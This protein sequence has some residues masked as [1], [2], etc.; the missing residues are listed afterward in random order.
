M[1]AAVSNPGPPQSGGSLQIGN[2]TKGEPY[3]L[4][5]IHWFSRLVESR[6]NYRGLCRRVRIA[7]FQT[8]GWLDVHFPEHHGSYKR[9][10]LSLPSPSI[11]AVARSRNSVA[12]RAGHL[13]PCA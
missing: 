10:R 1:N 6:G 11:L 2:T 8:A 4:K 9:Y 5:R 13:G 12:H 7:H 3:V